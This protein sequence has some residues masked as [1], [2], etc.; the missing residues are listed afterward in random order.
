MVK[1]NYSKDDIRRI[2]KEENVQFLRLMFTDLYGTIKNVEVPISQL[3][4]VLDNKMMFDG[5]SIDGFV[6]IEESDMWLY[7]D[8][9]TWM[10]FPWG[11][12]HGKVARLICEVYNSDRTPFLGD[13]RNNLIRVLDEMREL[14][15]TDFNIGPEPEFFLF[16]LDPET[17]KPTTHLNDKGSYFD[18]APIDLGE[19]CRRDIVLE[20]ENMGF[21]IEASHHEVAPGQHE[22]DFK[23]ADALHAC[24][25][26]Q[27]FKLVVKTVARKHGLH[28]T[29]MPKPLNNINGSGMHINMSLFTDKGNAFFDPKTDSQLSEQAMHFLGGLMKHARNFT[30]IMNP[31]V[32]S[33]K[34]LVPGYEAPVYVA[35]SGHNRSPLVRVPIA[36]G[37]STRLEL[38]SV[39]PSANPYLAVAAVLAAG[40]D[41][42]KNKLTPPKAVDRNIY[43]M[44]YEERKAN[45]IADLPSTL[46]NALKA[47]R[48]DEVI[49][50]SMGPHL[51]KNF[52]AAKGIEWDAY[53]QQV[54][55]WERDQYMQMY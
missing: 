12:E 55:Q 29:F 32:N 47:L 22:I 33:Y 52:M 1:A 46:H 48:K 26:I 24:D 21:D 17:G 23:Y 2:A 16:K 13:P 28:A 9:S 40:L 54:S 38:R 18:L 50:K 45:H 35:W 43:A 6:R 3:D 4:K 34:R 30:A 42:L 8:L 36:R 31:I 53:R 15:F 27:T 19:N 44:D 14:G 10:I 5:S 39:D 7:P 25:N 41:G 51:Y 49:Q 11:S 20:L 37:A